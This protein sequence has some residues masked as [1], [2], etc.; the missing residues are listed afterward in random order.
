MKKAFT[1]IELLVAIGI[2]A[3]ILSFASVIFSVSVDSYRTALANAEIM[4]KLRV[5]TNQ[6]NADF[7][8]LQKDG[9][10][11]LYCELQN[12]KEYE[13]DLDSFDFRADRLYYFCTG[14]FQSWIEPDVKS[15]I[16]RVYFGHDLTSVG[17]T[18]T[19]PVSHWKLAR[20]V[21][22]LTPKL[23]IDPMPADCCNISYSEC[24]ANL[25]DIEDDFEDPNDII[26]N[27][28][29]INPPDYLGSL[30]SQNAG[31]IKIEWTDNPLSW[32]G[33]ENPKKGGYP[34]EVVD[35]KEP[36]DYYWVYWTPDTPQQYWPKALKLTFTL[37]DSRA[38]MKGG[39]TF[40]HI[41]Y[42][43]N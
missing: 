40:T 9:Y 41:V 4:Q 12:R 30:M 5:I 26:A 37:Y 22:L 11:I 43:D 35:A 16:A 3:M 31:E 34:R 18:S 23:D 19:I 24:R 38:I 27:P 13:E 15:N 17:N 32:Y 28:V 42:L 36:L 1:L 2:L 7:Q 33:L 14:D 25:P 6:L 21:I 8:G 39:R 20:D 29:S 10:L